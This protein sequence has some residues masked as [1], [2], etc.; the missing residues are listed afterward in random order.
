MN[1]KIKVL[2]NM[3]RRIVREE[4]LPHSKVEVFKVGDVVTIPSKSEPNNPAARRLGSIV[5]VFKDPFDRRKVTAYQIKFYDGSWKYYNPDLTP[6]S[7]V[8]K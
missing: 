2:E 4:V 7:E 6:I 3:I 1:R 5:H 8:F